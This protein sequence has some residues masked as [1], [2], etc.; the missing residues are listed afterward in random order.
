MYQHHSNYEIKTA[1][2]F[3]QHHHS[4]GCE[5]KPQSLYLGLMGNCCLKV[6]LLIKN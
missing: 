5:V 6:Y 3:Y 4:K 1:L 2:H